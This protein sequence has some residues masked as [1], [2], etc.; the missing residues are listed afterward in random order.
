[1]T[2]FKNVQ[3]CFTVARHL[4]KNSMVEL[5]GDVGVWRWFRATTTSGLDSGHISAGIRNIF[6]YR[7]IKERQN[8]EQ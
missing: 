6:E 2:G 1:M 8:V 5:S 7:D 4:S 3:P